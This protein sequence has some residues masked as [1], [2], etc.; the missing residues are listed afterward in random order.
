MKGQYGW[1]SSYKA[2]NH[3]SLENHTLL[4]GGVVHWVP[5]PKLVHSHQARRKHPSGMQADQGCKPACR[6]RWHIESIHASSVQPGIYSVHIVRALRNSLWVAGR[7]RLRDRHRKIDVSEAYSLAA[8]HQVW[9]AQCPP[10]DDFNKVVSGGGSVVQACKEIVQAV[11]MVGA[12]SLIAE[13]TLFLTI[14]FP[15]P[16]L[17]LYLLQRQNAQRYQSITTK[18]VMKR[19]G[20]ES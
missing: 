12:V 10:P 18:Q 20:T 8:W 16:Q 3:T 4:D 1:G 7:W 14:A 6:G 11:C 2:I 15:A 9:S 17:T 19:F 13:K 5:M